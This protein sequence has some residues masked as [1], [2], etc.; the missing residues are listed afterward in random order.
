MTEFIASNLYLRFTQSSSFFLEIEICHSIEF[1][2]CTIRDVNDRFETTFQ[3]DRNKKLARE[4][5]LYRQK[6]IEKQKK[7]KEQSIFNSKYSTDLNIKE[8]VLNV[9]AI[10]LKQLIVEENHVKKFAKISDSKIINLKKNKKEIEK[11]LQ[12]LQY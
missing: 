4:R 7:R 6:Q 10:Y 8:C 9:Q 1:I 3:S 5:E 11:M 2:R 12:E